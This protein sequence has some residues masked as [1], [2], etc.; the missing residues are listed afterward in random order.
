MDRYTLADMVRFHE[1][2][3]PYSHDGNLL[4][5]NLTNFATA[6]EDF[7]PVCLLGKHWEIIKLDI[8]DTM[9]GVQG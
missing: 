3:Y 7:D 5:T 2:R 4:N 8:V 1:E 9:Y 6:D